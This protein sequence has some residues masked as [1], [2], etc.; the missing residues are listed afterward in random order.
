MSTNTI[1]WPCPDDPSVLENADVCLSP[2]SKD[3][4]GTI[5]VRGVDPPPH[6]CVEPDCKT[7]TTVRS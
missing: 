7:Q 5:N 1:V 2:L 4:S 6:I 3:S